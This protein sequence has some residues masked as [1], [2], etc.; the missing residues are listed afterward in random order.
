MQ[1]KYRIKFRHDIA[2]QDIQ[3]VLFWAVFNTQ[4]VYGKTKVKM[5]GDYRFD[6]DHKVCEIAIDTGV[7]E[8]IA[9]MFR[10]LSAVKFGEEAFRV[11]RLK[12]NGGSK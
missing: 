12:K 4:S 3:D 2:S 6:P 11:A 7:K 8:H 5:D 9:R 10:D 1:E